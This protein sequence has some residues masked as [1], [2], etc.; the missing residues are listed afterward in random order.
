MKP[1]HFLFDLDDTLYRHS[2]G[3]FTEISR[4][5]TH[6]VARHCGLDEAAAQARRR[7]YLARYGT[8]LTGLMEAA[9]LADPEPFI[10]EVH[11]TDIGAYLPPDPGL[12][13]MLLGLAQPKSVFTNSPL[14]HAQRVLGHFGVRDCFTQIFDLRFSEFRGKPRAGAYKRVLE[15]IGEQPAHVLFLDD[16]HAY[17][18]SYRLLGGSVLQVRE[19]GIPS[20]DWPCLKDVK[21]LPVWLASVKD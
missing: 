9:G 13:P 21:E 17:L 12:R 19:D 1:R 14:E 4:R 7:E 6:F 15:V 20:G 16:A 3:L 18:E 11:P 8:T 2:S 10:A 5:M